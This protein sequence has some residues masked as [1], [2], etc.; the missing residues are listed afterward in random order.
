[1]ASIT[2]KVVPPLRRGGDG[3]REEEEA[4]MVDDSYREEAAGEVEERVDPPGAGVRQEEGDEQRGLERGEEAHPRRQRQRVHV[5]L[6]DGHLQDEPER[7]A[8]A[9]AH[10]EERARHP[11][12]AAA[13]RRR[14]VE[15]EEESVV[16]VAQQQLRAL[17]EGHGHGAAHADGRAEDL[18]EAPRPPHLHP[19]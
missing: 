8:G 3:Q 15:G 2:S 6:A 16:Q 17:E 11:P 1:M 18:G 14:R 13:A 19:L 10:Q 5:R 4:C 7:P 12:A 9:A